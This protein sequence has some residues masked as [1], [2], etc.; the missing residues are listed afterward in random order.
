M[1]VCYFGTYESQ[2]PR[3]RILIQGLRQNGVDVI[4]VHQ[5]VWESQTDKTGKYL[6]LFSLLKLFLILIIKLNR[7]TI[8]I[9]PLLKKTDVIVVGYI[10][11]IDVILIKLLTLFKRKPIIFNSLI[12]IYSTLV[13]D[14]GIFKKAS[15]QAKLIFLIDKISFKLANIIITDTKRQA[16][17]IEDKFNISS[18]KIK[19]IFVGA[20]QRYFYPKE[21]NRAK[22]KFR[23]LFYGKFIPL[24]G[25]EYI[26]KATKILE[27]DPD[28]EFRIIGSGQIKNQIMSLVDKL[29]LV[30]TTFIDWVYY[31]R[32]CDYI[33]SSSAC[34]GVFSGS[35]K[36]ERVIPNKVFQVIASKVALITSDNEAI[37]ELL[38]DRKDSILCKARSEKSLASA[39]KLLRDDVVLRENI[40][41]EGFLTFKRN[42]STRI[43]GK[44][45]LNIIKKTYY[46][47]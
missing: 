20:D 33:S 12:S 27:P 41:K 6:S 21:V 47:K 29:N 24:H 2:Y 15:I 46:N 43:L 28:I 42:C 8:K 19:R 30:N 7:L 39:I 9:I 37:R 40:R 3:N 34:L 14:R 10:G 38:T 23:V 25:I 13:E 32:L 36:A 45:L 17:Y 26:I 11:Q 22:D 4:E 44:Q 5:S 18:F 35:P 16:K 31:D 1:K